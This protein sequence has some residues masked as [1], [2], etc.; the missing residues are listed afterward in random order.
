MSIEIVREKVTPT[1]IPNT[2]VFSAFVN[3]VHRQYEITPNNGY[4]LH[5]NVRDW[6]H[7]APETGEETFYRGY[8]T[9]S[10]SVHA[11]YNFSEN[12]NEI[13]AVPA[14]SVPAEQI[15]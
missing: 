1:P 7:I 3:G 14:D 9:S 5:N 10:S 13:Y 6:K 4:V 2:N 15:F 12:P 11:S 8:S